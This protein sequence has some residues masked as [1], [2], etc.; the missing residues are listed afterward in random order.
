MRSLIFLL[1]FGLFSYTSYAKRASLAEF[2]PNYIA[3]QEALAAGDFSL[4]Q[5]KVKEFENL[6][7]N[8][9]G[10][11]IEDLKIPLRA[12]QNAK[13]I[14]ATRKLFKK[15][16]KPFVSLVETNKDPEFDIIYCPMAGAKWVQRRGEIFNPYFGKEMLHCGEKAL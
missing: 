8:A 6:I 11:E 14:S 16:S 10:K 3:V 7:K 15:I 13:S 4:A 9:K 1:A 5:Q 12:F 2:L